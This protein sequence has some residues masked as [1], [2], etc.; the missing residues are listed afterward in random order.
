MSNKN[1]AQLVQD[2][3]MMAVW[4]RGKVENI[5][6]HS[7]Q[8]STYASNYYQNLLNEHK[9]IC[10]MSRKEECLDNAVAES[11][12]SSSKTELVDYEN[13]RSHKETRKSLFE[14]VEIFYS[15]KRRHSYLNYIGP[16]EFEKRNAY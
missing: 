11:F 13:Y 6:V 15:R 10:R 14:Y 5:I 8:G 3:L 4:R 1:K 2:A 7:D 12:F 16:V 9:L